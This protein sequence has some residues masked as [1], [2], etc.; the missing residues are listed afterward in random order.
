M[1]VKSGTLLC[2]RNTMNDGKKEKER[3]Q[4]LLAHYSAKLA[5]T[6]F[7]YIKVAGKSIFFCAK[8]P[9]IALRISMTKTRTFI[10]HKD[11]V[12]SRFQRLQ[13]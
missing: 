9:F 2:C 7:I 10:C 8:V 4:V 5:S 1:D 3:G 6:S 12:S 11:S 13:H